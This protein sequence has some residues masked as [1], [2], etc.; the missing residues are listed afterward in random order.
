MGIFGNGAPA[1]DDAH[2]PFM[3]FQHRKDQ[4]S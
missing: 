3:L 2:L 4:I 1:L